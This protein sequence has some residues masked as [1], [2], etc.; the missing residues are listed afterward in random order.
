[1]CIRDRVIATPFAGHPRAFYYNQKINCL[2][3]AGEVV[4]GGETRRFDPVSY[5]HLLPSTAT[6][7]PFS[8][9]RVT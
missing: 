4:F 7:M 1:M 6:G 5:T 9:A 2:T 8:K 3:A